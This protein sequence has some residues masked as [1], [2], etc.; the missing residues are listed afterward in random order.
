MSVREQSICKTKELP[1]RPL[2]PQ[3][4]ALKAPNIENHRNALEVWF[5]QE[6]QFENPEPTHKG[7]ALALH[8]KSEQ[9]VYSMFF[10]FYNPKLHNQ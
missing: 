5:R 8:Q 9:N 7:K 2:W 10:H 1:P 4:L 3:C 6:S